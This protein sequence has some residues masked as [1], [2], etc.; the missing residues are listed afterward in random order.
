MET[1]GKVSLDIMKVTVVMGG[2]PV[3]AEFCSDI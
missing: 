3:I 2:G 1:F